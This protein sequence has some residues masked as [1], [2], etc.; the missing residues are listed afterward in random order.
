MVAPST[1]GKDDKRTLALGRNASRGEILEPCRLPF[2]TR[3]SFRRL[4]AELSGLRVVRN[5]ISIRTC[6]MYIATLI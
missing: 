2:E 1:G 3:Q 4:P 6:V 5:A